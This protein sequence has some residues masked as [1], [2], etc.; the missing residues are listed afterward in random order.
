VEQRGVVSGR[1]RKME[2]SRNR[3]GV[4]EIGWSKER[5]F[6]H[7][8]SADMLESHRPLREEVGIYAGRGKGRDR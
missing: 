5:L 7:S 6:R 4:T 8:C 2:W 1:C 3:A